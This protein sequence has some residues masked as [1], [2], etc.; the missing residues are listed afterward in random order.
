MIKK[1]QIK[2]ILIA[3]GSLLLVLLVII[4][5][6]NVISWSN[7]K[8][9]ADDI[10][11]LLSENDGAFPEF[12]GP[13][14]P[15]PPHGMTL[16]TPHES[17]FF[18]VVFDN[19]TQA[20][21]RTETGRIARIDMTEAVAYAETAL[22]ENAPQGF[23]EQYRYLKT[24]D[25]DHTRIIFL[26]CT[27]SID[28]FQN[29][30]LASV[31]TALVGY[32]IVVAL[33]VILSNWI[34]R[35]VSESYEK[36]KRFITDAGH[37]IKTPLT[38]IGADADLLEMEFGESEW[39]CDIK[40][41]AQRLTGLTNDL[42]LLARMEEADKTMPMI[43]FPISDVVGETAASFQALAQT[44][45]KQF[46]WGVQPMLSFCGNEKAIQQLVAILLDNAFKYSPTGGNISVDLIKQNKVLRLLVCNTTIEPIAQADLN[47][48]F[49]RFYRADPSRNSET[50]GYG[51]GLSVAKAIVEAHGGKIQASSADG[52]SL[53]MTVSF[54][55]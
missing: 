19:A 38:I 32:I 11:L 33:I 54:T 46:V 3:M 36:Q 44:Q 7:M 1:L 35:P 28:A 49:E 15:K 10:L 20:V 34:I 55:A 9:D 53:T 13:K 23:V 25:G 8:T 14:G 52:Q 18:W 5:G 48:L 16:E 41:Q 37:E 51:I 17:R 39:L 12:G 26:D 2:F 45:G 30:L 50:G 40:K 22:K 27:R 4:G 47:R 43:D 6:A 42:V 24:V 21:T 31:G 29:F